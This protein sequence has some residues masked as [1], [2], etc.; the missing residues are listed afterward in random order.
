[1]NNQHEQVED[2]DSIL[3]TPVLGSKFQGEE[4]G[5]PSIMKALEED[6]LYPL[7]LKLIFL[8]WLCTLPKFLATD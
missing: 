6:P 5:P 7:D 2:G 8:A 3:A 4:D 1:M